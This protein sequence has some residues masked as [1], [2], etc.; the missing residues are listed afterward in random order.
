MKQLK[1][2]TSAILQDTLALIL[3]G[4]QGERL[5]PLTKHRAKPAVPFGGIYRIVDFALSNCTNS[6]LKRICVLTQYKS[7]SLDRHI[8]LGWNIFSYERGEFIFTIPPQFRASEKW[9]Q[10]TADAVYQ[11]IYTIERE[12]PEYVLILCGDHIY[13]MDYSELLEFHVEAGADVTVSTI[14]FP[15]ESASNL[16]VLEIDEN[17]RIVGFDEKPKDPKPIPGNPNLV[18]A[19]MGIYVFNTPVLIRALLED[20]EE[21]SNHDF[22]KDVIPKLIGERRVYAFNFKDMNQKEAK[23]WRDVGTIDAYFD[24]NMDLIAI[25]PQFNLYDKEWPIRTYVRSYPPAKTVFA[26]EHEGRVGVAINSIISQGSIV[27][28]GRV[29]NSILSP[30]VR[31]NSYSQVDDCILMHGV[32]VGRHARLRRVIVDK[33]VRIPPGVEIGYNLEEDRR[34]FTVTDSG[35][36]VIPRNTCFED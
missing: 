19:S 26:L 17:Q 30:E 29:K 15:R 34:K 13:K 31:I 36:V 10:G 33:Y 25:D 9:Y 3:A 11:N 6:Q 12:S 23:Y 2:R 16:G 7:D 20:A 35:I 18:M 21:E 8:R 32:G 14:E 24:A 22:G 28:G 4:G 5:Y 27:S 1:P